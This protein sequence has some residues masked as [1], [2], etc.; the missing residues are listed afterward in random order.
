MLLDQQ[1]RD[2]ELVDEPDIG[3]EKKSGVCI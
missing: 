3:Q 1:T 2:V